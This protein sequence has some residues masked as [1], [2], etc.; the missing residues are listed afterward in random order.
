VT[1]DEPEAGP[2]A[3]ASFFRFC[4][5]C[6]AAGPTFVDNKFWHCRACGF[7]FFRNAA[8]A[9]GVIIH[10]PEG[11]VL[12][13]RSLEPRSGKLAFPGGFVDLGERAEEA[14]LRE[15]REEIG[16][17]PPE[18]EYLGS[19]PNLYDYG[20]VGYYTCDI[21][22]FYRA[23]GGSA[24]PPLAPRDGEARRVRLLPPRAIQAADLA[25]PSTAWALG[26]YAATLG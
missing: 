14:A 18:I 12:L 17:A 10:G 23:P 20:G 13:E 11:I 2:A 9:A 1:G 5:S 22:Y 3:G 19:Y 15:C 25:F 6:G 16:W 4:P 21:F 26:A 7:D 24:L 8:A